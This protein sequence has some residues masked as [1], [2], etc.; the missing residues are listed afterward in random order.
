M[1]VA[2]DYVYFCTECDES[3]VIE[4]TVDIGERPPAAPLP[5]HWGTCDGK[6]ICPRCVNLRIARDIP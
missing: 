4:F 5:V 6:L 1:M 3:V 2:C